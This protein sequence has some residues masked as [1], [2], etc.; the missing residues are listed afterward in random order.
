M[1]G[2]YVENFGN[3]MK[4]YPKEHYSGGRKPVIWH[5]VKRHL[6]GRY[7]PGRG[8]VRDAGE[9]W[10]YIRTSGTYEERKAIKAVL[11]F[12]SMQIEAVPDLDERTLKQ[13]FVR[14]TRDFYF[15]DF[16]PKA[17]FTAERGGRGE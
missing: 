10:L 12:A 3:R 5:R 13:A 14:G 11:G 17:A 8:A 16:V 7:R 1:S 6:I 9:P 4:E 15:A 2:A